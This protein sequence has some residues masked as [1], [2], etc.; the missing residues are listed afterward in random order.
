MSFAFCLPCFCCGSCGGSTLRIRGAWS[1]GSRNQAAKEACRLGSDNVCLRTRHSCS[2]FVLLSCLL[3]AL[4]RAISGS[5]ARLCTRLGIGCYN[6]PLR[7]SLA[8]GFSLPRP[9]RTSDFG[10]GIIC[11]CCFRDRALGRQ[12]LFSCGF[13]RLLFS[14]RGSSS[15]L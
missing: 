14:F 9:L 1:F 4:D 5:I 10:T 12:P 3:W 2:S 11:R 15:I 8:I 13:G 7:S 6:H